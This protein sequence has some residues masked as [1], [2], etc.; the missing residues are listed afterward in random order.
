MIHAL[1][2]AALL[3]DPAEPAPI[4]PMSPLGWVFLLGSVGFVVILTV[5]CFYRVLTAPPEDHVVKPP[6][7][8]GG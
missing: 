5:W 3:Q 4:Q 1:T 2:L 6:D 8:L 7:S